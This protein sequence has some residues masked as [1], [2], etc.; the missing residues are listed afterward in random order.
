MPDSPT[1]NTKININPVT[2]LHCSKSLKAEPCKAKVSNQIF[3]QTQCNTKQAISQTKLIQQQPSTTT[4]TR[5]IPHTKKTAN[6]SLCQ[7]RSDVFWTDI[8]MQNIGIMV[9]SQLTTGNCYDNG[10]VKVSQI[11]TNGHTNIHGGHG[12]ELGLNIRINKE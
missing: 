9:Q 2:W 5:D 4:Q 7:S 8:S 6:A 3:T 11:L 1:H 12:Q 10:R